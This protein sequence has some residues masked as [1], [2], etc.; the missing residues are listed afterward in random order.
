MREVKETVK[1]QKES[2]VSK[3]SSKTAGKKDEAP[4]KTEVRYEGTMPL[5][6]AVSYFEALLAGMRKGTISLKQGEKQLAL[7]PPAFLDVEV[8]AVRKKEKEKISFELTWRTKSSSE[9][10]ISAQ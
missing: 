9:L 1:E 7:A 8:K 2:S 10:T 5:E 4:Q 3:T 6:E